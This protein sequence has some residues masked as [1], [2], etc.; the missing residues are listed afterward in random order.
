MKS[1]GGWGVQSTSGPIQK[2]GGGG[3]GGVQSAL[4]LIRKVGAFLWHTA[5]TLSLIINSYNFGR[6]GCSS[7]RS[8]LS[9]YTTVYLCPWPPVH[10]NVHMSP[11]AYLWVFCTRRKMCFFFLKFY[12]A[13]WLYKSRLTIWMRH[14]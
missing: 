7:T 8:T 12:L 10:A 6:G 3:G 4:G 11:G 1:G 13:L 14:T 5:N 9:G 2:M